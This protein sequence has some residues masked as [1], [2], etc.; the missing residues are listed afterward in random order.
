MQ[1]TID[2][3]R[4]GIQ[5]ACQPTYVPYIVEGRARALAM[6]HSWVLEHVLRIAEESLN[7]CDYWEF[8]RLLE[9]L[10][11]LGASDALHVI[12]GRGLDSADLDV[13]EAAEDFKAEFAKAAEPDAGPDRGG[14]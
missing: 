7:L 6:P 9:L 11:L 8:R 1:P 5:R 12:I 14:I 13:R 3:L 2:E 4:A 10:E